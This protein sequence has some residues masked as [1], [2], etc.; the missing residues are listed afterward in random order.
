LLRGIWLSQTAMPFMD[1]LDYTTA[2]ILRESPFHRHNEHLIFLPKL[3]FLLDLR[4]GGGNAVNIGTILL[5]QLG[6]ALVLGWMVTAGNHEW[7]RPDVVA[8]GLALCACF[9]TLQYEWTCR[10]FVPLL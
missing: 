2:G 7:R 8:F 5:N 10:G 1:Q 3:G 9:S 4:L 6:H